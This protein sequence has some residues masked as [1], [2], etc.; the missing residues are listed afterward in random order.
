[1]VECHGFDAYF[2]QQLRQ[3]EVTSQPVAG[4]KVP[5][6][7]HEAPVVEVTDSEDAPPPVPG[8]L[9]SMCDGFY[10]GFS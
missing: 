1:M 3:L 4:A 7:V 5:Q 6:V 2:D 10:V 9:K 8:L